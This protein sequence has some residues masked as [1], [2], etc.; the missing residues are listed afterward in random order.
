MAAF[1]AMVLRGPSSEKD[2]VDSWTAKDLC[3][4]VE[5]RHAV[6]DSENG[7]PKLLKNL[8]LSWRRRGRCTRGPIRAPADGKI[9]GG[10]IAE[11]T[12]VDPAAKR[13]EVWLRDEARVPD[14]P[15][16]SPP[17]GPGLSRSKIGC[18]ICWRFVVARSR[19]P[20]PRT[21]APTPARLGHRPL[22][23]RLPGAR[24][25]LRPGPADRRGQGNADLPRPGRRPGEPRASMPGP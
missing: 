21:S 23:R 3:C 9:N 18:K 22:R 24:R 12:A 11:T 5:D 10:L 25:R 8:D 14:R 13:I 7:M 16:V 2:G 1:R 15:Q 4:I 20:G 6:T 17:P 19:P